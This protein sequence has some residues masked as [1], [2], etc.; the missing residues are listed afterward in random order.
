M[1]VL[2]I[3]TDSDFV[4][5]ID[6][7]DTQNA[8]KLF[9]F[10]LLPPEKITTI[11]FLALLFS[12]PFSFIDFLP[13]PMFSTS[14]PSPFPQTV[15]NNNNNGIINFLWIFKKTKDACH[16]L[17]LLFVQISFFG[18]GHIASLYINILPQTYLY[19]PTFP[20]VHA[21]HEKSVKKEFIVGYDDTM[22][23]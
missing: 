22:K 11:S 8:P 12:P 17:F 15:K 9:Y 18:R 19:N 6:S 1:N 21:V 5:R 16:L 20:I 23:I 4:L 14:P 3:Q 7:Q 10:A 13:S 2:G